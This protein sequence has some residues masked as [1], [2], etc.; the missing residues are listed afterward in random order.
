MN[1]IHISFACMFIFLLSSCAT[2]PIEKIEE[3]P[4]PAEAVKK[5]TPE[6]QEKQAFE[7]F[8]NILNISRSSDNRQ[9]ILPKIEKS[10][11][12]LIKKYPDVPLAQES[13]MRLIKLYLKDYVPPLFDKAET[14]YKKF[15]QDYPQSVIRATITRTMVK[16]Y[17]IHEQWD[18]LLKISKP[19]YEEYMQGGKRP[20]PFLIFMYAESNYRL[21]N[22]KE[23]EDGFTV[24]MEKFPELS[25]KK[26]VKKRIEQMREK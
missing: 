7:A 10:Y 16:N 4:Q 25:G 23:A 1:K 2:V 22:R 14:F 11:I 5:V 20:Q 12:E 19:I 18:R 17:Y 9:S 8:N 26:R 6:E 15:I 3:I 13:Y 24:I 21:G